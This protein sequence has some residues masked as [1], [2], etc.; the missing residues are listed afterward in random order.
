MAV[1]MNPVCHTVEIFFKFSPKE[2]RV[3]TVLAE[4]L[5]FIPVCHGFQGDLMFSSALHIYLPT[6]STP[7]HGGEEGERGRERELRGRGRG[8]GR[9]RE[10]RIKCKN[11]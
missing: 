4:D 3:L 11:G 7:T 1:P 9:D 6:H 10:R 5:N 2:A 8:R